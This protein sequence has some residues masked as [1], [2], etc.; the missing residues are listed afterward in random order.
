[1]A[2]QALFLASEHALATSSRDLKCA[3]HIINRIKNSVFRHRGYSVIEYL[4]GLFTYK[5]RAG[6]LVFLRNRG[7]S[8]HVQR[9]RCRS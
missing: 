7:L 5:Q 4:I 2:L 8:G 3:R 1:M 6:V 9:E